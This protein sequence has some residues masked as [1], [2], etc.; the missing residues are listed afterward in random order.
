MHRSYVHINKVT[1]VYHATIRPLQC[2]VC[3][4][5]VVVVNCSLLAQLFQHLSSAKSFEEAMTLLSCFIVNLYICLIA[6]G[7]WLNTPVLDWWPVCQANLVGADLA[8]KLIPGGQKRD[9]LIEKLLFDICDYWSGDE[10]FPTS[11]ASAISLRVLWGFPSWEW[12]HD[13]YSWVG[14]DPYFLF[15]FILFILF[16]V[17][18]HYSFWHAFICLIAWGDWLNRALGL[19]WIVGLCVKLNLV[20]WLLILPGLTTTTK[21]LWDTRENPI[22]EYLAIICV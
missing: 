3:K 22:S 17:T 9:Y 19:C 7:D 1:I 18:Q 5:V 13:K 6:W 15:D 12:E 2:M 8:T 16:Y 11:S 21:K 14:L 4:Y 20:G 10:R